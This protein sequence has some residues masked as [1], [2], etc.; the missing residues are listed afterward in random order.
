MVALEACV[1]VCL[2]RDQGSVNMA[3]EVCQRRSLELRGEEG[4]GGGG[5]G[6][7]GRGGGD[8][9]ERGKTPSF[10]LSLMKGGIGSSTPTP[11]LSLSVMSLDVLG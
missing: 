3:V 8:E 10:V 11:S 1:C 5:G 7:G 4:G 2:A 6:G 9:E